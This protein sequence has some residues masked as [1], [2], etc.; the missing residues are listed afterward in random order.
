MPVKVDIISPERVLVSREV[1]MAVV[2]GMEGDIAA[3]PGRAPLML[4]LRGGVVDL[5]D[6]GTVTD[7]YFVAGGFA[8]FRGDSC[9]I[10]ADSATKL[11]DLSPQDAAARLA[12]A[13]AAVDR[14]DKDDVPAQDLLQE[15][16]QSARAEVE[17]AGQ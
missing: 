10:L 2:P 3:M 9:T 17:A 1:D 4:L 5:H 15:A 7:R 16:V 11:A 14:A 6:G 8:D 12:A 13:E